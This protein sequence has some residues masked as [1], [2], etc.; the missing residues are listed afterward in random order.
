ME[1]LRSILENSNF[2]YELIQH[3]KP[4]LSAQDGADYFGIELG[5][6]APTLI[7]KTEKGFFSLIVS[8][9][10]GKVNF[11][12]I[13]KLLGCSEIKL[14]SGKEVKQVTGFEVGSVPLVGV[15]LPCILDREL[16]RYPYIYGGT[17][18]R[19]C[20]LKIEPLALE[21][22]NQVEGIFG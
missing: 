16:Y 1:Q 18:K 3:E 9:K 17:G 12:D 6:T 21:A 10:R 14:A 11:D 22:L 20:T 8:G 2:S 19:T 15:A 7:I 13:A 5:Q 4:I